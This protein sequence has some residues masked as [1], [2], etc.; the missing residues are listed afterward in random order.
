MI[1]KQG[2]EEHEF[3]VSLGYI[4]RASEMA[5]GG[6]IFVSMPNNLSSISKAY[7]VERETQPPKV[8]PLTSTGAHKQTNKSINKYM[9][10][11]MNAIL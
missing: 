3:E 4:F 8:V 9:S 6:E 10:K 2:Q 5:Q 7:M 1:K 11:Q